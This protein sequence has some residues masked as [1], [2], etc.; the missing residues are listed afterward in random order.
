MTTATLTR[1]RLLLWTGRKVSVDY[2][3]NT[4]GI[5]DCSP[6]R[7][8]GH[9]TRTINFQCCHC[10]AEFVAAKPAELAEFQRKLDAHLAAYP[11]TEPRDG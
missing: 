10:G 9:F 4:A 2:V 8:C 7:H 11:R 3:R 1:L 6:D 5:R